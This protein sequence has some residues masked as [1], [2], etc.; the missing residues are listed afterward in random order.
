MEKINVLRRI[1]SLLLIL[2]L[3]TSA[4]VNLPLSVS[5]E[6]E[7]LQGG[8][9]NIVNGSF[10]YPALRAVDTQNNTVVGDGWENVLYDNAAYDQNQL[11]WK[12]T[13]TNKK[14]EFAWLKNTN[15][16]ANMSPH[17]KPVTV[18]KVESI[19]EGEEITITKNSSYTLDVETRYNPSIYDGLRASLCF[20]DI[21]GD[22]KNFIDKTRILMID[23]SNSANPKYYSYTVNN[24]SNDEINAILLTNFTELGSADTHFALK[25][26]TSEILTEKL[27]FIV[28]YVGTENL[29]ES[30]KV[31]LVYND[32]NNELNSILNPSK[33]T[34][35]ISED[36]TSIAANVGEGKASSDGPFAINITVTESNPAINTTYKEDDFTMNSKYAV[37]LSLDGDKQLPDGSYAEVD[38][39]KYFL[40][41]GYIKIPSLIAGNHKV[42]VYTPVPVELTDGKVKFNLALSD[43]VSAS[44][45]A[46][47]EINTSVEFTCI[48]VAMDA[49]VTDKVLNPGSVLAVDVALEYSGIDE[50]RLNI[51]K[52]NS[53]QTF[54]AILKNV[55]V[56]LPNN[57]NS[58]EV[59]LGNGFTALSGKTYIFS[60]VGYVGG[61]PVVEDKCCVVGG[62]ISKQNNTLVFN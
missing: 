37:K 58:F 47:A 56:N 40:C 1:V 33:K 43:A 13:A 4:F 42:S 2:T 34:V 28:D 10:E 15:V 41:N 29:A 21:N 31:S 51:S 35:N 11:G 27:V 12:T 49:D 44:P 8:Q 54:S 36:N 62:Y 32:T 22:A 55:T 19:A 48:D 38:G 59:T 23:L 26:A 14:I 6:N 5:A 24:E 50:V 53:D 45:T 3:I 52:K 46:P 18:Q 30:G 57:E 7:R 60:F 20:Y 39:N 25:T 16:A 9:S 17:M 61:V